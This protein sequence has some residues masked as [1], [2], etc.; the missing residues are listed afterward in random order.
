MKVKHPQDYERSNVLQKIPNLAIRSNSKRLYAEARM[1]GKMTKDMLQKLSDSILRDLCLEPVPVTFD[2]RRP[3][4]VKNGRTQKET[5]GV[6]TSNLI[7]ASIRVYKLTAAKGQ[8][9]ASKSAT[10]TLIHE[11]NHEIDRALLHMH[12]YHTKGFYKRLTQLTQAL[13]N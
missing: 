12:S 5:H 2:G 7:Y 3:R 1:I 10:S 9:V 4:T 11:I 13:Q 8:L 6:H